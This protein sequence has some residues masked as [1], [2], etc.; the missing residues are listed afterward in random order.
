MQAVSIKNQILTNKL[1][2]ILL[3]IILSS[4]YF[5][6]KFPLL[7]EFS[8]E[9]SVVNALYFFILI[10]ILVLSYNKAQKPFSL[11]IT[12]SLTL[13]LAPL[14]VVLF[15]I[16]FYDFC[17]IVDGLL[18]Y[19]V[20]AFLSGF[21][22]FLLSEISFFISQKWSYLFYFFALLI[23]I[24]IPLIELYVYPQIYFYSSLIGFFPGS[25]YDEDI[26][27]DSKLIFYRLLNLIFFTSI[28][29]LAKKGIIKRK[30]FLVLIISFFSVLFFLIS[31]LLGFS[32]NQNRLENILPSKTETKNFI[33]YSS[34]NDS[35]EIKNLVLHLNYYYSELV[36]STKTKPSQ[37]ITVFLFPNRF[38]RR[39]Y[40]GSENADV[41]KP[42]LYQIYLDRQDWKP[43]LKH[44]LA[45]I[46]SAEF[47]SSILKLAG[48]FN[49]FLIEGFA[50]AQDPFFDNI[51]IDYLVTLYYKQTKSD[52]ISSIYKVLNFFGFNSTISYLYSGSF[53]K[54]LIKKYGIE[55]FKEFYKTNDFEK[56]YITDFNSVLK[57]YFNYL[58]TISVE[59][60]DDLYNYYFGRKALIEKHCPRFIAKKVK[61]AWELYSNDKINQAKFIYQKVL[62]K[63]DNYSAL[64]GYSECLIKQDSIHKAGEIIKV[65]L[66]K[67]SNTPYEYLLKFKLADIYSMSDR[68]NEAFEIY[69]EIEL[70]QANLS[71]SNTANFR[72]SLL[73][74]D[75]LKEYLLSSD[76]LK[77]EILLKLNKFQYV[78]S[79]FP[80]L[81]N[82][83]KNLNIE[84]EKFLSFF[85]KTFINFNEYSS[86]GFLKLSQFMIDNFDFERARKMAALASRLNSKIYYTEYLEN[87]Y[88]M[89]D[90]F[91]INS[92]KNLK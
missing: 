15:H 69:S 3:I 10:P 5:L 55:K 76:S 85:D 16:F 44:E 66:D 83:S 17:S 75:R 47:G 79:S 91:Y 1:F 73:Q 81:I 4:N 58:E 57:E 72:I 49:P 19:F 30:G 43:S 28:Y 22:A 23:L 51:S 62:E 39:K 20:I 56:V 82:L 24:L 9:F 31:P 11:K 78:Y 71:L 89:I 80:A 46:F 36:K 29:W 70:N 7:K 77:L 74:N 37:K 34:T 33:I 6:L 25:I 53:S 48:D 38:E 65:R 2:F 18:F 27:I 67:F 84:Y 41:T 63:S 68:M 35:I 50:T 52:I 21:I 64:I 92:V 88:K 8:Y 32:T 13:I 86:N 59:Q 60:D 90:W 26:S 54:F 14:I 40:F 12:H 45:H 61:N 42:W 87:N